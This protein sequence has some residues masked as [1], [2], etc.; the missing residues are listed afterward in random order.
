MYDLE[1]RY[2]RVLENAGIGSALINIDMEVLDMNQV[3]REWHPNAKLACHPLCFGFLCGVPQT[4]ACPNCPVVKAFRDGQTH[5]MDAQAA[6]NGK[7]KNL[8]LIALPVRN[9]LGVVAAVLLMAED[10]SPRRKDESPQTSF[11]AALAQ[12]SE[13]VAVM[14]SSGQIKY[15]NPAFEKT[16][17][18]P[19][20]ELMGK[21]WKDFFG[22][23]QQE[24]LIQEID[25]VISKGGSWRGD[26]SFRRKG[27]SSIETAT[28]LFPLANA[29]G[30]T[31]S[32]ISIS[33]DLTHE[34]Q[35]EAQ[36]LQA[37]KMETV[38]ILAS[39]IAHDFNNI[40][41]ALLGYTELAEIEVK[42]NSQAASYVAEI[43]IAAER[44][45][46]LVRHILTFTRRTDCERRPV[47]MDCVV[48]E[49]GKL[50]RG[51]IP[52][53]IEIRLNI[54][55]NTGEVLGDPSQL[56]QVLMNLATNAYHA[57]RDN[58]GVLEI[59]LTAVKINHPPD[60]PSPE[61]KSGDYIRLSI[62]DTGC[63]MDETTLK[64]IFDPYF[65]TKQTGEG[66]GLGLTVVQSIIKSHGGIIEAMSEP[67]HGSAFT[68]LLPMLATTEQVPESPSSS[69]PPQSG[70]GHILLVDDEIAIVQSEKRA[71]EA[72]G[73]RVT[74]CTDS[75]EALE[76]FRA[77][78]CAF[79]IVVTD[80]TMPHLTGL[81][82][83]KEMLAIRPEASV[84]LCTGYSDAVN[85]QQAK[86]AGIQQ[87]IMKPASRDE[88][89]AV[90]RNVLAG[91]GGEPA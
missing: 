3:M 66:T 22:N 33:R 81:D 41:Q 90:I 89:A 63:G 88:L 11:E 60:S 35:L 23:A 32:L 21:K 38:G 87:F 47:Q 5:R 85:E 19:P 48:Q 42:E 13:A 30:D 91:K 17:G 73:Y 6:I 53:T 27:L 51:T 52:R 56:H 61:L 8:R 12:T 68:I 72:L 58:G 54:A 40:L 84:V 20:A 64:S 34:R 80:Q 16:S 62:K 14:D 49:V 26:L 59:G 46:D 74:G 29:A 43:R 71:F 18:L 78:P 10:L 50:L 67:G 55:E 36:L 82:L 37:Q 57:M 75:K 31:A 7:T 65:T 45:S 69:C 44:A 25:E 28:V 77:N 70:T 15:A 83:A 24:N 39:G 9:V 1:L 79:D 76:R 86:T 4:A 2:D